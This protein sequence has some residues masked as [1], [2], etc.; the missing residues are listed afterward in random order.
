MSNEFLKSNPQLDEA[1]RRATNVEQI[2]EITLAALAAQGTV[3]RDN[4]D[5]FNTRVVPGQSELAASSVPAENGMRKA[6]ETFFRYVTY[7]NSHIEL[8]GTSEENLD[9][10][11]AQILAILAGRK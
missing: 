9:A 11:Q 4:T 1:I 7:D 8:V 10:K 3:L 2:R 5:A 6:S